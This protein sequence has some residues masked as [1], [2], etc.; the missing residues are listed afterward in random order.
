MR[1]AIKG[2]KALREQLLTALESQQRAL[3]NTLIWEADDL[4]TASI[5]IIE[6]G[7]S[8]GLLDRHEAHRWK[9]RMYSAVMLGKG[10]Q[11]RSRSS[12][13]NLVRPRLKD[14]LTTYG[15]SPHPTVDGYFLIG[16][17][18]FS[19]CFVLRWL[20]GPLNKRQSAE[21]RALHIRR[22]GVD[23]ESV[24]AVS[25]VQPD[26]TARGETVFV[27]AITDEDRPLRIDIMDSNGTSYECFLHPL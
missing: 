5:T 9:G 18:A 16:I 19:T 3:A 2:N 11:E 15:F 8:A 6:L 12:I 27:P 22:D 25:S 7:H 1:P 24:V 10:Q 17:D 4:V 23:Y 14:Y 13:P 21:S 20:T 26:G